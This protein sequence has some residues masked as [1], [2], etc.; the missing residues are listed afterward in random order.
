MGPGRYSAITAEIS[1]K[2]SGDKLFS[3]ALIGPPSSWNT[4]KVSPRLSSWYVLGSSKVKS[5]NTTSIP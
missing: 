2:E 5:S 4:P 3:N 1:W